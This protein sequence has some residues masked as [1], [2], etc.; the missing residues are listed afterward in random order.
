MTKTNDSSE[1]TECR[2]SD[3]IARATRFVPG[4]LKLKIS[5]ATIEANEWTEEDKVPG[6]YRL[7]KG[8]CQFSE[9]ES[10]EC[11][12]CERNNAR[13]TIIPSR[14][15]NFKGACTRTRLSPRAVHNA[16]MKYPSCEPPDRD[17]N[18][19]INPRKTHNFRGCLTECVAFSL[20]Y[21]T[22]VAV[23]DCITARTLQPSHS[24]RIVGAVGASKRQP[25]CESARSSAK[26]IKRGRNKSDT[27][28]SRFA[29]EDKE[30]SW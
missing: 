1:C 30:T 6:E 19:I 16:A 29:S 18:G 20:S 14:N 28:E 3:L 9:L 15:I 21:T 10:H 25:R 7:H 11:A 12:P 4:C 5:L 8:N 24:V 27:I 26:R 17:A 2:D 23:R 13:E 22:R